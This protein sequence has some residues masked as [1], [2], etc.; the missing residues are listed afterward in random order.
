[1]RLHFSLLLT[2]GLALAQVRHPARRF[3]EHGRA[4]EPRA[5]GTAVVTPQ[6]SASTVATI[7]FSNPQAKNFY[8]DG[9][10]IPE[11]NFDAG[12]SWSGKRFQTM[13]YSNYSLLP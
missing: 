7:S 3:A 11:V 9:T 12:P 5:S 1:M 4:V 8:V 13:V 10:K 6:P 2:A